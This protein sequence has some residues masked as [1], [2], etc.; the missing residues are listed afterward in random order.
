MTPRL[1]MVAVPVDVQYDELRD[2][3]MNSSYSRLPVYERTIDN[4]IGVIHLKDLVRHEVQGGGAF[5]LRA[6]MRRNVPTVPETLLTEPLLQLLKRQRVHMAI[7][8]DEYGGTAGLVT[9]EDLVEEVVGEV[10]DEFD[11]D[12]V[13]PL[14]VVSEGVLSISG[15]YLLDD[16]DDYVTLGEIEYDVETVG[17]LILAELDRP[18]QV[19]DTVTYHDVTFTVES[20]AGRAVERVK[21]E[22]SKA[23]EA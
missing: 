3:F 22:F 7:V 20:I 8:I 9:L 6:R 5:N 15:D 19:G 14:T 17:G 23:K 10:R 1:K 13:A 12:E 18:P 16:L 21:V 2:L 11:F 4:I